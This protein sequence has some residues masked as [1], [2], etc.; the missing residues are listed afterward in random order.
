MA[1][2]GSLVDFKVP[3]ILQI[4]AS[5]EKTGVLAVASGEKS[6]TVGFEEG[7][8]TAASYGE[9]GRQAPLQEFLIKS[10]RI[11]QRDLER[12]AARKEDT[13]LPI[14]D[15]LVRDRYVDE[16]EL[17]ELIG[18]KIQEVM[19]ELFTWTEGKFKFD[20]DVKLYRKSSIKVQLNVQTLLLEGMRRIDEWPRIE[21]AL[22]NPYMI[23][24]K[25]QEPILPIELPLEQ[26]RLLT[27]LDYD[28]TLEELV[29]LSGL[30]KFR[31]YHAL[32]NLIEI[33]A[34][35]AKGE[36]TPKKRLEDEKRKAIRQFTRNLASI[37]IWAGLALFLFANSLLGFWLRT[38]FTWGRIPPQASRR[39]SNEE[40]QEL[41]RSLDLYHLRN[42]T[43]PP[44]LSSLA[45]SGLPVPAAISTLQYST[46][47]GGRSYTLHRK[48]EHTD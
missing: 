29:D 30:G 15:I 9:A 36:A 16:D 38:S 21:K 41:R 26:K 1:F 47:D 33:G 46:A 3:D 42:G 18:F 10:G 28:R 17:G 44:S 23:L 39:V 45:T 27:L 8:V 5:G 13:G 43:Y 24:G 14:E 37:G 31:T 20:A 4:I 19:D 35:A 7:M 11:S 32:Y 25:K 22:P 12:I 40:M 2:E 34:I 48:Q 6:V